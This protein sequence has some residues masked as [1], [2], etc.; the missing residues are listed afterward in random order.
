MKSLFRCYFPFF[1]VIMLL[2][3]HVPFASGQERDN[4]GTAIGNVV[5]GLAAR[6]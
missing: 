5:E 2:S 1:L 6:N 4:P 3:S